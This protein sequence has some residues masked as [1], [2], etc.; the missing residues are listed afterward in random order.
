MNKSKCLQLEAGLIAFTFVLF[1]TS[2]WDLWGKLVIHQF[3]VRLAGLICIALVFVALAMCIKNRQITF[4][5]GAVF[6]ILFAGINT[7]FIP[8]T[9]LLLRS[10]AYAGW[11]WLY[12]AT[13]FA[14]VNLFAKQHVSNN[15]YRLFIISAV[16]MS[17]YGLL[18]FLL[19]F[20]GVKV[21]FTM[22]WWRAGWARANGLNYEPSFFAT[23]LLPFWIACCYARLYNAKLNIKTSKLLAYSQWLIVLAIITSSSRLGLFFVAVSM[24]WLAILALFAYKRSA[25]TFKK[26][27]NTFFKVFIVF[28]LLIVFILLESQF[29]TAR[30]GF[31][32]NS[33][34]LTKL[35][36]GRASNVHLLVTN[37]NTHSTLTHEERFQNMHKVWEAFTKSPVIGRSFG[38]IPAAIFAESNPDQRIHDNTQAKNFLGQ[39]VFLQTL[40]ATG[41]FGGLLFIA[42]SLYLIYKV[43]KLSRGEP[44][45]EKVIMCSLLWGL[46]FSYVIL[47]LNQNLMRNYLWLLLAM[48]LLF[49]QV[50]KQKRA[51]TSP[52][53]QL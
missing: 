21:P 2:S 37:K 16:L 3:S 47:Q 32:L 42:F 5:V 22:Q 48:C 49:V 50:V 34:S 36:N 12:I 24:G 43:F 46:I 30:L 20:V 17:V 27:T 10:S 29:I 35:L 39:G 14:F 25:I 33:S 38:G 1:L 52:R 28:L 51:E 19:P 23:Y 26:L 18:Q 41:I 6:L 44:T 31:S 7:L 11:L 15:L 53:N 8:S 13:C 40:L 45:S 9:Y 4:P